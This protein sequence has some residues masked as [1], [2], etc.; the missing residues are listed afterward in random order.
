MK[1]LIANVSGFLQLDGADAAF[2]IV[3]G[4]RYAF[5]WT[6]NN[7]GYTAGTITLYQ[8]D[9]ANAGASVF[10]TVADDSGSTVDYTLA[11]GKQDGGFEFVATERKFY[12]T[13]EGFTSG[14]EIWVS[15][16]ELQ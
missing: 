15:L 16:V 3:P 1:K 2:D 10:K 5:A 7:A 14:N 8:Y 13:G 12:V 11:S 9:A 4:K 6:S